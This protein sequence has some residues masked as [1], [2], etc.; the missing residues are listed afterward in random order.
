MVIINNINTIYNL[1]TISEKDP[2]AS[3]IDKVQ[4]AKN[5]SMYISRGIDS[6]IHQLQLNSTQQ[7]INIEDYLGVLSFS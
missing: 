5:P 4:Y 1:K 2:I 6:R 3:E 7:Y